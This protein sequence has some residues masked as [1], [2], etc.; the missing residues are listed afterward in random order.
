MLPEVVLIHNC[1]EKFHESITAS[2]EASEVLC[3]SY[4][5]TKFPTASWKMETTEGKSIS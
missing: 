2:T 1:Q 3:L 4:A 5:N